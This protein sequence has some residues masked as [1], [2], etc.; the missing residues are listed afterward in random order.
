MS[1]ALYAVLGRLTGLRSEGSSQLRGLLC[2]LPPP[3]LPA[4]RLLVHELAVLYSHPSR[5]SSSQEWQISGCSS[6]DAFEDLAVWSF[7]YNWVTRIGLETKNCINYVYICSVEPLGDGHGQPRFPFTFSRNGGRL[8]QIIDDKIA[9]L[10]R[11]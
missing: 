7:W 4:L 8:T 5:G 2:V 9:K 3:A 6:S 1:R 10:L 11:S